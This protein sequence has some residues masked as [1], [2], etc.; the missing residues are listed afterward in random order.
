GGSILHFDG[1]RLRVG[2]DSAGAHPGPAAYRK[3]GPLTVTDCNVMLG[4]LQPEFF[5]KLF[6]PQGSAALDAA[7]VGARFA[8]LAADIA[9]ASGRPHTPAQV[10]EGY[11]AVAVANMASAIT[12]ISVERGYDVTRYTLA[13]FGGAGGQHACLVADALGM[14]RVLIHPLAGVLS[15][16]G[17][18]LADITAMRELSVD[19]PLAS[20]NLAHVDACYAELEAAACAE[21]A[22]QGIAPQAIRQVRRVH[23]RYA[24]TDASLAVTYAGCDAMRAAFESAYRQ[25]YS[26]LMQDRPLVMDMLSVEATGASGQSVAGMAVPP[27]GAQPPAAAAEVDMHAGGRALRA[28]IY[29]R[30]TLGVGA[31][32][33]GPAIV[34]DANSTTVLEPGWQAEV[35]AQGELLLTRSSAPLAR[36]AAGTAADPVMLEIFNNLF[37]SVAEQMGATLA[38]TAHSVNIKERLDFSCALFDRAGHLVANAPHMPVHLGSMGAS[39]QAV[40]ANNA[41]RM[42]PGDAYALND[43]YQGGTHLPDVT[44]VT[45]V[46]DAAGQELLFVVASRGHHADIG[47]ITPGSMPPDSRDV[48]EEGVLITN[49]KLVENGRLR[50]AELRALLADATWPARNIEQNL[51]DLA[52]Q[53]AA[54][55]KGVRELR[56]IVADFGLD[57]VQAYM[58][59]VQ[60]NAEAAVRRVI[61]VLKDGA[62]RYT[63]DNGGE[64]C[65]RVTVD[66]ASRSARVDFSGSSPQL[67]NNFN[68]PAAVCRAAVLYVFRTLVDDDIPLNDGCLRPL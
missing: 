68:A 61:G 24:G 67:P 20:E 31:R 17:M 66:R 32:I 26:F 53:L 36:R 11:I 40:L 12:K 6:G 27:Q 43:P 45:P 8:A 7:G 29:L 51:A 19:L 13:C 14:T 25:R 47:G 65:V 5:P 2:P 33:A 9:A 62:F 49:F 4:K 52:A 38:N 10:A 64:I 35:L 1:A 44:V 39:I 54:N 18:G 48:T 46:F 55:E 21:V 37:M 23:L 34:C 56:R 50:E 41:G 22:A 60:D 63:M 3:G 59:H 15:A 30:D 42:R 58:R 16:Y 28:R 57:V